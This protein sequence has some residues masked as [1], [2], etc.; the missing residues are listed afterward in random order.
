[1]NGSSIGT[2]PL[3]RITC[4]AWM[5]V[6]SFPS[7]T[8]TVF[9]SWNSAHPMMSSA[10]AFLSKCSTPLLSRVTIPSFQ[11]TKLPMF[12]SAGPGIEIPIWPSFDACFANLWN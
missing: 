11:E 7:P 6:A 8:L 10:P 1:M 2:D 3:A 4:S 5:M 12:N 9:A